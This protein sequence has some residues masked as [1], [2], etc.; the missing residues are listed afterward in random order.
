MFEW[1]I[2]RDTIE[3]VFN[4]TG[5]TPVTNAEFMLE[6]RRA[7]RRPWSPPIPE[8]AVKVGA[9]LMGTE[10]ELALHGRRC[11]PKRLLD[12]GFSFEY[13]ELRLAFREL[14]KH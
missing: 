4:A 6:L 11:L 10:A 2:E 13:P 9:R 7:L 5:P 12:E 8:W 1:A 14:L 3:G